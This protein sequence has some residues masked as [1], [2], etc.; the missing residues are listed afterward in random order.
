MKLANTHTES[1]EFKCTGHEFLA[2]NTADK[3]AVLRYNLRGHC[4]GDV[5][6]IHNS[7]FHTHRL[8]R[9]KSH[10]QPPLWLQ[11][12][13]GRLKVRLWSLPQS[14]QDIKTSPLTFHVMQL[15]TYIEI[16][17]SKWNSGMLA[18]NRDW[19]L[20]HQID[21]FPSNFMLQSEKQEDVWHHDET[22]AAFL[23]VFW[24]DESIYQPNPQYIAFPHQVWFVSTLRG[25]ERD[26]W[27]ANQV[28]YRGMWLPEMGNHWTV[29]G[30]L[31][32]RPLYKTRLIKLLIIELIELTVALR[33]A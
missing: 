27:N 20:I 7:V 11:H 4:T 2:R 5:E 8:Q 6:G 21:S 15:I 28:H 17:Q 1:N 33:L 19:E 30:Y 22:E 25:R 31:R 26:G 24:L 3:P 10:C 32:G 23:H 18:W 9:G 29:F 12:R 16:S 14:K 13:R